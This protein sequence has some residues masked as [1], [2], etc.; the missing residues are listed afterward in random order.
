LGALLGGTTA[1]GVRALQ[2]KDAQQEVLRHAIE[3]ACTRYLVIAHQAR[4]REQD[5]AALA[6]R[7]HAE[8]TGTVAAQWDALAAAL[9]APPASADA[10][11]P[12][13]R[14]MVMGILQRS[15]APSDPKI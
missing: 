3:A 9:K 15:F 1:W 11:Q 8:V 13:L 14:T 2:K 4:V 10:L 5:A 7:W 6:R 12:L